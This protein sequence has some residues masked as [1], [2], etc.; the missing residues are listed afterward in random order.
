MKVDSP[1]LD[2]GKGKEER[3][4]EEINNKVFNV[5]ESYD[6][7]ENFL[8]S[9]SAQAFDR[10]KP[11]FHAWFP[12]DDFP[13]KTSQ[14]KISFVIDLLFDSYDSFAGAV[15]TKHPEDQSKKIAKISFRN[16]EHR[17]HTCTVELPNME[18][19]TFSPLEIIPKHPYV[20]EQSIRVTE[21]PLDAT[22]HRIRTVFSKFGKIVH[23]SSYTK[24]MWQ[25]AT[26]TYDTN[27][28]FKELRKK[29]GTFILN[30]MVRFHMCDLPGKDVLARSKFSAKLAGL[31]RFTTAM[32]LFDIGRMINATSWIIP[33]ARSNY[34]HLQ[35][36]FFYFKT[37]DDLEAALSNENL[38]LDKKHVTW[39]LTN[40]K[41]CAICSAPNHKATDCPH[42]RKAPS[43]RSV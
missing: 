22:E 24:N 35:H 9:K 19:R 20:P 27:T 28:D 42:R 41:L 6:A 11:S 1:T 7:S 30:D 34:Q 40:A 4:N 37:A 10:P 13:G 18:H 16:K 8:D 17:D 15:A 31:P 2:K 26:I 38:T 12:L 33:R 36:A 5:D 14:Q 32:Q 23:F 43:D 25:Q 21:I 39:T 3:P 29:F